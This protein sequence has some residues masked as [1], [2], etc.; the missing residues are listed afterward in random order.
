MEGK[1][2]PERPWDHPDWYDLHD[3]EWTAGSDREPEHYHEFLIAMPPLDSGDH[4]VDIGAGTGKL[5]A[6]LAQSYPRLGMVTLVDPNEDKLQRAK[7]RVKDQLSSERTRTVIAAIGKGAPLPLAQP[8]TIVILGSVI[9]PILEE[10]QGT[11]ESAV[12]WMHQ[13]LTEI[14]EMLSP[15]GWLYALETLARFWV[16]GNRANNRRLSLLEFQSE[17]SRAGFGSVEC[18][19]RFRDRVI[20]RGQSI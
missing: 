20:V 9:M 19:Y 13:S 16:G 6:I 14:R 7:A 11:P 18:V 15:G 1:P 12:E 3:R 4:V 8:A 10:W 5:S 17:L 2:Y